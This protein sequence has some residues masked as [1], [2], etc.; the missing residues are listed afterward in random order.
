MMAQECLYL[1]LCHLANKGLPLWSIERT[2]LGLYLN[3]RNVYLPLGTV[4]VPNANY[5]TFLNRYTG[6]VGAPIGTPTPNVIVDGVLAGSSVQAAPNGYFSIDW[7]ASGGQVTG[8]GINS[9]GDQWY[10]LNFDWSADGVTWTTTRTV[11]QAL[12][13]D[14]QWYYFDIDGS[15][16]ARY[17]R[18]IETGGGTLSLR[19]L[20]M[21]NTPSLIP[22]AKLNR[23]QY[24]QL[25]NPLFNSGSRS[26]QFW[27]DKQSV[28]PVMV[29]WPVPSDPMASLEVYRARQ[30]Q[31][32]GLLTQLIEVPARWLEAITWMTSDSLCSEIVEVDPQ[33]A[34]QVSQKAV[35]FEKEA[36]GRESDGG[37]VDLT[38]DISAYTR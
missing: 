21:A 26:L 35:R 28:Q 31:D 6:A 23:D 20:I 38:P 7:G 36:W 9:F 10:A 11:S 27:Y 29:C 2:L 17:W 3:Q 12:Y 15:P 37:P 16:T 22:M 34:A 33:W 8:I 1:L 30:I 5:R 13:K 4:D 24:A 18:I 32:V 19:Q 14:A 25:V